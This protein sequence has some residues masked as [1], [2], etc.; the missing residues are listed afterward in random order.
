MLKLRENQKEP[1]RLGVEF[2]KKK[3]PSPSLIVA[4]TAFGKSIVIASIANELEGKT[5]VLQPSKELLEQNYNK[6]VTLGG[7]ASIYSAS[8]NK[9]EFGKITYATI[10]S[11]KDI[12][13]KFKE[14]GYT[15]MIID[16]A[17]LYP[18]ASDS[19][20]GKFKLKAGIKSILGL[21]ATPFRLQSNTDLTGQ[22]YSKLVM[23]S[24]RN[25]HGTFFKDIIHVTQISDMVRGNFWSPLLYEIYDFDSGG[26]IFNST[27][28][29]FTDESVDFIYDK[30]KIDEKL[31]DRLKDLDRNRILVFV[32][33]VEIAKRLAQKVPDS[34]CVYSG[35]PDKERNEII[36]NFRSG[37]LRIIFNVNILSVGFDDPEIDCIISAR[38]TASLAWFYQAVGRG[39]RI[40]V[41]T[42]KK[43]CL[44]IDF[45]GNSDRFGKIEELRFEYEDKWKLYGEDGKLL[46]GIPIHEIGFHTQEK[47]LARIE[48]EARKNKPGEVTFSFGKYKDKKVVDAPM[49]YLEWFSKNV[50]NNKATKHIHEE[51][52]RIKSV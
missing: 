1:V 38:P 19:M 14:L 52:S 11:I 31:I 12:G 24:S 18:R 49:F 46:T 48:E 23:L 4:P 34:E 42:N 33:S 40:P 5:I 36:S 6:L 21:T 20:F 28:A 43:D 39:T 7:E 41:K 13:S 22:R 37:K 51:I 10:G 32:P 26:L 8:F 50:S 27:K 44:I 29:E 9:K 15:N 2:F 3:N 25:K 16:E 45:V 30:N 17:H 47:E 35:I